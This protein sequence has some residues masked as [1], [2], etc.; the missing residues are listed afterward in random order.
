V[1]GTERKAVWRGVARY[2]RVSGGSDAAR[3]IKKLERLPRAHS[4]PEIAG[5]VRKVLQK[6]LSAQAKGP[7]QAQMVMVCG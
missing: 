5:S 1:A 2:R 3:S 7:R 4:S 6:R